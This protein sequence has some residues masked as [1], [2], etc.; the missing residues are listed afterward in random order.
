[1]VVVGI[2][3]VGMGCL[4]GR[5]YACAV[6]LKYPVMQGL[7]DSK[8]MTPQSREK[9]FD[10]IIENSVEYSIGYAEVEEIDKINI[11]QA[12]FLAMERAVL[13]LE[14]KRFDWIVVDGGIYPKNLKRI[15][16]GECIIK[17]DSKVPEIMAASILAKVTRDRYMVELGKEYPYYKFDEHKGYSTETHRGL[18]RRY[19]VSP[20][21]RRTFA[22]VKEYLGIKFYNGEGV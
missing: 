9:M 7:K 8:K 15:C 21:H 3:E 10:K 22:G 19:G 20:V 4:S 12:S 13:G 17:G 14:N 2:D 6:I 18:I 11:Q 5:V 16:A 1:M